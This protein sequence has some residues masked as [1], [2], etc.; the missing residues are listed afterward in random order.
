LSEYTT[1]VSV[2]SKWYVGGGGYSA[3]KKTILHH[4]S[5]PGGTRTPDFQLITLNVFPLDYRRLSKRVE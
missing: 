4:F 1:P 2:L 3:T 5:P